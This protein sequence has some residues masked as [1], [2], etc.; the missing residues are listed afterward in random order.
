MVTN[1]PPEKSTIKPA[2]LN[3]GSLDCQSMG[4]GIVMRYISVMTFSATVTKM[5]ILEMAGWQKSGEG[6][7]QVPGCGLSRAQLTARVG[8]D[9]PVLLERK[10][11]EQDRQ[12]H[13]KPRHHNQDEPHV[14]P[15]LEVLQ[16]VGKAEVEGAHGSLDDPQKECV[17]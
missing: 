2:F 10:T 8:I 15:R 4:R 13:G 3:G 16:A 14:Y 7:H 1:A 12:K 17:C 11:P 5:S 6:Q 9:L